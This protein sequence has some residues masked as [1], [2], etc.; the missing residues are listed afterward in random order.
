MTDEVR[1]L[2]AKLTTMLCE[3]NA[4]EQGYNGAVKDK[5]TDVPVYCERC[6]EK[7]IVEIQKKY[8]SNAIEDALLDIIFDPG[9]PYSLMIF[10]MKVFLKEL[11]EKIQEEW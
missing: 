8:F 2:I 10:K 5:T 6:A 9:L 11:L 7:L 1:L 4:A 3:V